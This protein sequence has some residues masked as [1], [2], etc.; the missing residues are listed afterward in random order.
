MADQLSKEELELQEEAIAFA[1]KN[2]KKIGRRL[3]DTSRFAP[4]KEPV[5]VFMAGCPGA[6]KTEAS[7]ELIDSVKDGDGEILRIDPDEL[8]SE[9]P[10]YTGDNSW[11]FQ[12]GVSILVEKVVDLALKQRQTFLLDGTLARY[13]VARRNV[14]RCLNKGRFVQILHV[15]QEPLQAWE[16]VQAREAKE[17]RR[18]LS[19]DFID[20]YFTARDVVNRLKDEFPD[21][22]VDLLLKNRDGSHRFYKANVERID[23]YIPEKYSRADL[24]RMLGLE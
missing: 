1:R 4:E 17:G 6:G 7:I 20:Q 8:R 12:G 16:F 10:G 14:E 11:L 22:R 23:N 19:E 21:I 2:K 15:Y 5:T 13:E 18:I 9:L 3:T 24:E